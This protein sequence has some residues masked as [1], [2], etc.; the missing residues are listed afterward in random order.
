MPKSLQKVHKHIAKKR[1]V[2]DALHE[3]SRDAKRLRRAGARDDRVARITA[4]MAR[5]RQTYVD[6]MTYFQEAIPEGTVSFSDDD[7]TDLV[8]RFINRSVPEIEQLQS[9]RRKGRPPTKREEA[10]LQRTEAENKEFKTGFWMPDLSQESVVK[11]LVGWNGDWSSLSSMK[12]IRLTKETGK[13][14]SIFPP[15]GLS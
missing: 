4:V 5:G 9:E 11:G 6:R 8:V 15:K 7:L 3:N 10:L 12:F 2:V 1:G 13:Q 14:A